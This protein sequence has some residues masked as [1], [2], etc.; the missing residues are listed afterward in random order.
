MQLANSAAKVVHPNDDASG[1][2]TT[3]IGTGDSLKGAQPHH[4]LMLGIVAIV[5]GVLLPILGIVLAV[6]TIAKGIRQSKTILIVLGT[7]AVFASLLG[8]YIYLSIYAKSTEPSNKR[9]G[10]STLNAE[11]RD[12]DGFDAL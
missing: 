3:V 6:V 10:T 1:G 8:T 9:T 5:S 2:G 4:E 7:C 11:E 12:P